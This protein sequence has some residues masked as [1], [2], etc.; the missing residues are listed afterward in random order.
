VN[1]AFVALSTR[2]FVAAGTVQVLVHAS[3]TSVGPEL[4]VAP[5]AVGA[6]GETSKTNGR[7]P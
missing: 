3:D 1:P 2:P 4:G 5:R 7:D 6:S